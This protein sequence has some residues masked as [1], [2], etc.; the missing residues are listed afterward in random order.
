MCSLCVGSGP[1]AVWRVGV[2]KW[3]AEREKERENERLVETVLPVM[4]PK[5]TRCRF[6]NIPLVKAV[7]KST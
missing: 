2:A 6:Y 7:T 1:L 3:R 4:D 5:V